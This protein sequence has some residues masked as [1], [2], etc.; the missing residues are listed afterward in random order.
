[1]SQNRISVGFVHTGKQQV[2]FKSTA[3]I[4]ENDAA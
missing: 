1:V 4:I 3:E 2:G